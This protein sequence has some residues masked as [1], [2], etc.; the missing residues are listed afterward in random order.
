MATNF[1]AKIRKLPYLTLIE[2]E[3]YNGGEGIKG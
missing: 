2:Q 3:D 1:G